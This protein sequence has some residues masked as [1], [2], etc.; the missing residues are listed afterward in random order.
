ARNWYWDWTANGP[1]AWAYLVRMRANQ[2]M[3]LRGNAVPAHTLYA[4]GLYFANLNAVVTSSPVAAGGTQAQVTVVYRANHREMS[5][6]SIGSGNVELA[7]P[8]GFLAT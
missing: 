6:D 4:Y 3:D 7:G 1:Y 5:W 8:A 2:V